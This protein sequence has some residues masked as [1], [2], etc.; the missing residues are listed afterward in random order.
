MMNADGQ[1][2]KNGKITALYE[3]LSRDDEMQGESNSIVNQKNLLEEYSDRNGFTNLVHFTD[4]GISGTRFDRPGFMNMIAEVENGNVS[5]VIVK[6]MSRFG[7]DYLRV[8]LYMETLREYGVRLIAV[9]ENVDTAKGDDD[10][11]PFRNI[12]AEWYARDTSKKTKSVLHA[13]GRSGKHMTNAAVYGY[14]KDDG[15]K[16]KWVIDP[17]AAEVVRRIYRLTIDGKGAFQIAR[18][19]TDEKVTRPSVYIALRDGGNYTPKSADEPYTWGGASVKNILDR[20]EYMGHTVNFR[21]Y[22]DSYK[23]KKGKWRPKEDW[24]IFE[25]TQE[26]IIDKETWE[27]AQK[28]R[29]VKRRDSA[30][31]PNPLTGLMYCGDCG[32]RMYNHRGTLAHKYD[33]QDSYAC[34]QSTKYPRKC[35]M[36]YIKTSTANDL[37]L[38]VIKTVSEFVRNDKE[39][40]IRIIREENEARHEENVKTRSKQLAKDKKRHD[41][42]DAIIRRLFEEKVSGSIT[43][44]RFEVLSRGYENEQ[45]ELETRIAELQSGLEQYKA[46][47]EKANRFIAI[48][49]KYTDFSEL[50]PKMLNEYIDKIVVYEAERINGKRRQRV[51]IYLNFIGMFPMPGQS[52]EEEPPFDPV[53]RQREIWRSYYYKRHDKILAQSA[54]RRKRAKAEKL[55]SEPQKTPE[56]IAAEKQARLEK[57]RA[58]HREYARKWRERNPEKTREINER[59]KEN[60]RKQKERT[61]PA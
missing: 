15:D 21:T 49:E 53:E 50:T 8:G 17:E 19:L 45:T 6:D 30:G 23:D 34:T 13:K 44:K 11:I 60:N 28:C 57:S 58:Y 16:N 2:A 43:A 14:K 41:E 3:R 36:H 35:T 52:E 61:L 38:T 31:E 22:K 46:D 29:R 47:G 32:H 5:A 10:F 56:E 12:I 1:T 37:V 55:K 39:E 18:M 54:E 40:F 25:N 59:Y 51:D 20:P 42:L 9:N 7:R 27:T 26:A 33:S 4:D 48:V 24:I